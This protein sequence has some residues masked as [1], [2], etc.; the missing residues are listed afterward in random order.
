MYKALLRLVAI[1]IAIASLSIAAHADQVVNVGFVSYNV[2]GTN[3]AEFD[4]ANFTGVNSSTFPD[5][6]FPVTTALSMT[7]LSLTVDFIGGATETFGSS[8]FTLAGDGLSFNGNQLS[9]LSG[10]PTGLF[11]ANQATL[12]G[13]FSPLLVSLNDGSGGYVLPDFS[14]TISDPGGLQD[15]DLAVITATI[16]EPATWT[17]LGMGLL[18]LLVLINLRGAGLLTRLPKMRNA[19]IAMSLALAMMLLPAASKAQNVK[20]NAATVPS[21]GTSGTSS[22]SIT[23]SGFPAGTIPKA[24]VT[25]TLAS[26]C[27][28]AQV[29]ANATV[30]SVTN[31]IGTSDKV[32]FTI[33]GSIAAA[34]YYV[35]VSGTSPAFSSSSCS[36][37]TVLPGASPTLSINTTNPVDWIIKNGALTI[38]YNSTS[39]AIWSVVPTGTVDQLTD[40]DPGDAVINGSVYDPADGESAIG[41]TAIPVG[42]NGPTGGGWDVNGNPVTWP[43]V[44]ESKGFYM[45]LASFTTAGVEQP[46]YSLTSDYLDF[47]VAWPAYATTSSG[48]TSVTNSTEYEEHFVVTPNDPGIHLYFSLNH[49]TTVPVGVGGTTYV[50]NTSGTVGGQVQWIWRDSLSEFTNMYHVNAD[51][52]MVQPVIT[53]L[54][55]VDDMFSSDPGREVQ[56]ASGFSTLD[57]HP[58]PGVTNAFSPYPSPG[59]IPEGYSRN[60]YVKYTF[61]GYEYLHQAHGA[62]GDKYGLWAV[63]GAGH[64][65]FVYGPQKQNL[66][67][68]G[69][70]ITIEPLSSHYTYGMAT[71]AGSTSIS[72]SKAMTRIFGPI[73]MRINHFGMATSSSIDGGTIKTPADMYA[74]AVA[75][76]ASFTNFYNNESVL[77][78][79]GYVPT[80]QRGSV[81]VQVSGVTGAPKTAWVVLSDPNV[82]QQYNTFGNNYW[83]DISSTGSTTLTNVVPGTYRLSVYV[84]GQWGEFREDGIVVT[85][86]TTTTVPT[87]TFVPE[88]FGTTIGTIG[89]PDR[90]AHEFLHGHSTVN[91][92]DQP[93]GYDDRDYWGTWNYWADFATN[94][95]NAVAPGAVVYNLTDGPNGPATNNPLAW[96]YTHWAVYDP[97]STAAPMLRR[98]HDGRI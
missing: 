85:A 11:G 17:M 47:W 69:N 60:Y 84:L 58:E 62:F 34:N 48:K 50:A 40:F 33:P 10:Y 79:K 59:G 5:E 87:V 55:P 28:G 75:A 98:R 61:G 76:G 29:G 12:T 18:G 57:L 3:V 72:A 16:P 96:N 1:P 74:D 8:Y 14:V 73:Y 36:E 49:P 45:D 6:T 67:F 64:D 89:T 68:T 83:A 39:G 35:S 25:V 66:F 97:P 53:P 42:W 51:L 81:S 7:D 38:D 56:D 78:S 91:L 22:V 82:N 44:Y 95:T 52:S 19:G 20:L 21:S 94:S 32:A 27:G 65:T 9:T 54:L 31:I 90:S 13:V 41:G 88:N 70:I 43:A 23:G 4:I 24:N 26:S 2:T 63:V 46:G 86:N 30:S 37:V 92:A 15:G 77:V 80:T 93:L 71:G